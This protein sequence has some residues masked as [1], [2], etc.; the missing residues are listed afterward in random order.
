MIKFVIVNGRRPLKAPFLC[1]CCAENL[2]A[3]YI[4]E[5]A[6]DL[7][8]CGLACFGFSDK[9]AKAANERRARVAS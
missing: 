7:K 9:M 3:G 5:S 4:R 2:E 6:T 1:A 8:Y